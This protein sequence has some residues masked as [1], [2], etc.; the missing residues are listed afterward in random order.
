MHNFICLFNNNNNITSQNDNFMSLQLKLQ[1][2]D[3]NYT[4]WRFLGR[5]INENYVKFLI[6][7]HIWQR[8]CKIMQH[9]T[10][11]KFRSTDEAV[12]NNFCLKLF[13]MGTIVWSEKNKRS[14]GQVAIFEGH[15][16]SRGQG[17][18]RGP[19]LKM[20]VWYCSMCGKNFRALYQNADHFP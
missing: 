14:K 1:Y 10:M 5:N 9:G 19:R 6:E 4:V 8:C 13:F 17:K 7:P 15:Q 3:I 12:R 16:R 20:T 2:N 18:F 11:K